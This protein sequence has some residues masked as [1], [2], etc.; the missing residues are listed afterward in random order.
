MR[1]SA[2][3]PALLT[4]VLVLTLAQTACDEAWVPQAGYTV[5][6]TVD[7][8]WIRVYFTRPRPAGDARPQDGMDQRLIAL[9]DQ[10]EASVDLALYELDLASVADALIA[11]HARGV[12]VRL[13]VESDNADHE[14]VARLQAGDVTVIEDRR[15]SG[16]MHHK[17]AVVDD[18]WVWTGSWNATENGTTRNNNNAVL[19]ASPALAENYAA[20]FE[21]MAAGQFGPTSPAHVPHPRVAITVRLDQGPTRRVEVESYFAPEDEVAAQIVAQIQGARSRVRFLAFTFTSEEIASAMLERARAGVVVQ[22]VIESRNAERPYSQYQRLRTEVH[23]LLP[24]GNP[25]TMH[26]KVIIVDDATVILGSY[27]FTASADEANDENVLVIHDPQVAAAFVR[28]FGR[29]YEQARTAD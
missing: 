8:D 1:R 19:V 27:N 23:D 26:H 3:W 9:I 12:R 11:A 5:E 17:F 22:G 29:V 21:E 13:V 18:L 10:A 14:A 20:E 2:R 25:Y 24:D 6:E 7:G 4:A 16:L 15:E 28:E